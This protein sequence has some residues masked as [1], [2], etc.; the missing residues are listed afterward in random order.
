MIH[1]PTRRRPRALG[2]LALAACLAAPFAAAAAPAQK[3]SAPQK[4][5]AE[6][7]KPGASLLPGVERPS[8]QTPAAT[9]LPPSILVR[10]QG[11]PG[12]DRYRLQLATDERFEDVV[13]DQA[14]EGRQYVVRDLPPGNY[15]W[16]VAPAAAETSVS[17]ST[18]ERVSLGSEQK[19]SVASV[20]MPADATGWRVATGEVLRLAPAS[21]RTGGVFDF[22]GVGPDGRVFAVDGA[23]GISLWTSRFNPRAA[24]GQPSEAKEVTFDPL[25][26]GDAQRGAYVVVA[27][28]GG[29]RA[30]LGDTGR[31]TWRAPLEG[32]PAAGVATDLDGDGA[33]ELVVV[34]E[35]PSMF[36]VIN[37]NSGRVVASQKLS[38]EVAGA[39][40]PFTAGGRR[41]VL[42]GLRKGGRVE[43]RGGDGQVIAESKLD[44]DVTTAPLVTMRGDTPFMAVGSDNGLWAF[45]V[46]EL[47]ALGAIRA[48]DDSVRGTLAAAD[49]DGDGSSE[50]VMV[51]RRGRVALVS[52]LDGNV[53][54]FAEGAG[55][56]A[57]A[58]FADLNADG[59]LDVI[60][61]GGGSTFALAFSGRD[62]TLVMKVEEGGRA[63]GAE[64]PGGP[65]RTLVVTPSLGGGGLLVGGDPGR[66]G[67]RAVELPKGSVKTAAK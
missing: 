39:P 48:D 34:T 61:P 47:R 59:V 67:L 43:F 3:R 29:V 21:L 15:F 33:P 9:Q 62:G 31:E 11:K 65:P 24:A 58:A 17:Y 38:G 51:T 42:L 13:F 35:D 7:V 10:W 55:D 41:G 40:Y 36:Y 2:A 8:A 4:K 16:R 20:V 46:P 64:K 25:V 32:R 66:T 50:I 5:K 30:L 37:P 57:S 45:S 54:W 18:P 44:G 27:T 53:R 56:A 22:V 19:V 49:V 60:V 63:G 6:K 52:T 14:V 1:Q 26:F 28:E 12:V 23:S